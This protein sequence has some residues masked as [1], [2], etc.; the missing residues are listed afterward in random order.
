MS[1]ISDR[2]NSSS[3][4]SCAIS[5]SPS[6]E[7]RRGPRLVAMSSDA[8]IWSKADLD[9]PQRRR[10][11]VTAS[12]GGSPG[13]TSAASYWG[14]SLIRTDNSSDSQSSISVRPASVIS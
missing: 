2:V 11:S 1:A 6:M 9:R 5:Y 10:S 13:G 3:V 7:N 12:S 8:C 14:N 4:R